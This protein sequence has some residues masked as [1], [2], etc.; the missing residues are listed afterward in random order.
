MLAELTK[1]ASTRELSQNL[2]V[3]PN[4]VKSQLRQIYRKLGVSSWREAADAAREMP[5]LLGK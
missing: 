3:S 2:G 5:D 1:V 4:T